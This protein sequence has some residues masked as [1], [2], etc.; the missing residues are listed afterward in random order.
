MVEQI[1]AG[2][3]L[4]AAILSF[5]VAI[6]IYIARIDRDLKRNKRRDALKECKRL[7]KTKNY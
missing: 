1:I 7:E 4:G 2:V 3:I 5:V 6:P